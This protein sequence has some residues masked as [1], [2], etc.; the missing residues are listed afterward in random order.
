M[1]NERS[2][3]YQQQAAIEDCETPAKPEPSQKACPNIC[4]RSPP[5]RHRLQEW[6]VPPSIATCRKGLS[7]RPVARPPAMQGPRNHTIAPSSLPTAVQSSICQVASPAD[8]PCC[9]PNSARPNTTRNAIL[10]LSG[11]LHNRL[12]TSRDGA[13]RERLTGK[14]LASDFVCFLGIAEMRDNRS[15]YHVCMTLTRG[16]CR[17]E[18][19]SSLSAPGTQIVFFP[20][21]QSRSLRPHGSLQPSPSRRFR[22]FG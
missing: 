14:I 19:T 20:V 10:M 4:H 18:Y 1:P 3:S 22:F 9:R 7:P 8:S 17:A 2:A 21:S 11:E 12:L 16:Q 6:E 5:P 13:A 15:A